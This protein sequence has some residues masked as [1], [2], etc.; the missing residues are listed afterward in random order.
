MNLSQSRVNFSRFNS[1]PNENTNG[2][3]QGLAEWS[4]YVLPHSISQGFKKWVKL[5]LCR[6]YLSIVN[7]LMMN[8]YQWN[9]P[10]LKIANVDFIII[11]FKVYQQVLNSGGIMKNRIGKAINKSNNWLTNME[12]CL[13]I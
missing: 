10:H 11:G 13:K 3:N 2:K 6:M 9:M 5:N 12:K 1:H 8:G 4:I 7:F